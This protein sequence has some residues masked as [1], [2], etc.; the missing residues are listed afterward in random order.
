ME[1]IEN[2]KIPLQKS[3]S[4]TSSSAAAALSATSSSFKSFGSHGAV[5]GSCPTSEL[6]P[7]MAIAMKMNS[8]GFER[9][10]LFE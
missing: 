4:S 2:G 7:S 10:A 8:G 1:M 6:L 3:E 9:N 5:V